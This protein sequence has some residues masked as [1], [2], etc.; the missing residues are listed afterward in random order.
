MVAFHVSSRASGQRSWKKHS[1]SSCDNHVVDCTLVE[2]L[3]N[4][5]LDADHIVRMLYDVVDCF[6]LL[7]EVLCQF[8]VLVY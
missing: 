5:K 6:L 8:S 4:C 1:S 7:L 2:L 3:S